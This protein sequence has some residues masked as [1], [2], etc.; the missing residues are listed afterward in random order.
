M[1]KNLRIGKR[2]ILTFIIISLLA[3]ISG[4]VGLFMVNTVNKNYSEALVVN[5]FAQ[6][7]L[8]R[9]NTALNKGSALVRDIIFLTNEA[10]LKQTQTE[11]NEVLQETDKALADLKVNCQSPEELAQIAIIDEYLPK[12]RQSRENVVTLGL[13]N[14]NDEALD[15]F[16]SEAGPYLT[17]CTDAA[18]MLTEMNVTMGNEVSASLSAQSTFSMIL[19][20]AVIIGAMVLSI[21]L[22]VYISKS[23]SRPIQYCSDRLLKLAEGDLHT[24]VIVSD[25]KDE[26]G[27]MLRAM[28]STTETMQA[29]ISDIDAVLGALSNGNLTTETQVQYHGDFEAIKTS[30]YRII[31]SLNDT[32]SQI[33]E[34]ANQVASGSEQVSAGAQSLSQGATEQASSV[35]E[36]AAT[37]NE[38]SENVRKNA[39]N[40][41]GANVQVDSMGNE[42]VQCNGQMQEMA[43]AMANISEKSNEIG[44]IIKVIEDIAFQTNILALNAAVEAARAGA[45]GKGFAVVADEVRNLASKSAEAAKNTT[46]LIEDSIS[47]VSMGTVLS[48]ET[49]QTLAKIVEDTKKVR[50]TI[51]EIAEASAMQSESITQVTQGVDQI[52]SVVQT[53]S[54]TSEES[55]ASSEELSGQA[56]L[57]KDLVG[58][59]TL[60]NREY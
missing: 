55:A 9:F 17:K 58:R 8:G 54:A 5:G 10:E 60:K 20:V 26:T 39:E 15:L 52:S 29:I 25:A 30:I 12:Y 50:T 47:A 43:N 37:I 44:K 51:R 13:A 2:L 11:L 14:R 1:L 42:V 49:A 34:S 35:E 28:K 16:R 36:L 53:N 45:A 32:L 48:G 33:N 7:E 21:L 40:A 19:I 59:F 56:Q 41:D 46:V 31:S 24:P 4:V 22:G 3:S 38:I 23:I 27:V 57:L 6:G 18:E